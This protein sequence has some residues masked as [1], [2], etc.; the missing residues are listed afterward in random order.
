M[1]IP[2]GAIIQGVAENDWKSRFWFSITPQ[3]T[4]G[5]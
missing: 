2:T 5:C 1:I 4:M 3:V